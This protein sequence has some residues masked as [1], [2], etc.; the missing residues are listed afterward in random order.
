[1][2]NLTKISKQMQGFSQHL[3]S[4]VAAS[5]Q[6]LEL[7]QQYLKTA[8]ECQEELVKRQ[9]EWRHRIIFANA[10]PIEPLDTCITIP[11]PPKVHTVISTDGSQISPNH[12]E[13]AYCYLLNI[14]RVV[15]HYGQNL[16]P[17][18]DSIPEVFYRPEDLYISRQWG[19]RTDEWM[20][21]RRT[22]SE[23]TVLAELA[24]STK[25]EAPTLAM[26]DGSLI[27]WFLDQL[28]MEARD[29]ILPPVLE[30]W[31]QLRQA[32]IP[33]MGYLS[34]SRSIDATNFLRFL[35]CPHPVPDCITHC[36]NQLEYVPC[37]KFDTLRD[38]ALWTT[39]LQPGQRGPLWRSN[40]RILELYDDQIIYF[41]YV[42]V[43]TEI[44]RIEVPA[45]VV[46]NSTMF[47]QA[48]GLML[49]QVHKGYGYP[50]AIAEAHNQAV[51]RGADRTRFFAL[52]ERQMI[53]AGIKNV[54]I[55]NKEARKRGSI[56]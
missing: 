39:Q 6:R 55:S 35:A 43:G 28:P 51:V 20:G 26:I 54:G 37:K 21:F 48:L 41:C 36:P 47:D 12:H 22:A 9:E 17:V 30:S 11:V 31:Q 38:T 49:A 40:A 14:G 7:A 56:A 4:E 34:A 8:I 16:H 19:I 23:A 53:K 15:L 10:T 29:L 3:T 33:I 25:T 13:I 5:H 52:L 42:H 1:M 45:W 18:L 50:V 32:Q 27:Y 44:A 46:E 2:L 24:C